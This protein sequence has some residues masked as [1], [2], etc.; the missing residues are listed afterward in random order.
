MNEEGLGFLPSVHFRPKNS[1]S[2]SPPRRSLVKRSNNYNHSKSLKSYRNYET[3]PNRKNDDSTNHETS[4]DNYD[5]EGKRLGQF[6]RLMNGFM[7]GHKSVKS[8]HKQSHHNQSREEETILGEKK[9]QLSRLGSYQR[10]FDSSQLGIEPISDDV[11]VQTER[12][13]IEDYQ[14]GPE[15]IKSAKRQRTLGKYQNGFD[16][17]SEANEE[18]SRKQ[19]SLSRTRRPNT[20]RSLRPAIASV[21]STI[22]TSNRSPANSL[23]DN[24]FGNKVIDSQVNSYGNNSNN[25]DLQE[26]VMERNTLRIIRPELNKR[27]IIDKVSGP[28]E[29]LPS[30]VNY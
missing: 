5:N 7:F 1:L 23:S 25:D 13:S 17:S 18:V 2:P 10:S 26:Y 24:M 29:F 9:P 11:S 12:K 15:K 4:D 22:L 19:Q 30:R 14:L 6:Q 3:Y 28:I 27:K 20:M 16:N 21:P 8:S